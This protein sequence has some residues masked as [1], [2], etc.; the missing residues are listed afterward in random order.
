VVRFGLGQFTLQIPPWDD[1]DP[2]Q[3]YADTLALAKIAE[4]AGFSSFW[5]AE[6]HGAS[7]SYNP[8]LLPFLSAVAA[9]TTTLELGTAV[10]LAPFHNPLRVAEDAAVVDNI[11]GGRLNLGLGLGWAP[12]EYKMFAVEGKGRGKRLEEFVEV[13]RLAW[14]GEPFSFAGSHLSYEDALVRPKPKR[15]I[16]IWLG[17]NMPPAL[18]RAA[19]M[20][21]GHFPPSTGTPAQGVDRGREILAI[22]SR[23]G[24][25]GPF[26]YGM[27]LPTGVGKDADDG[28]A[29]IRDG[30]LHVRGAY[31]LWGQGVTDVTDAR[32]TAAAWED[33]IR[34][35]ALC[36]SPSEILDALAPHVRELDGMGFEDVFISIILAPPGTPLDRA[37]EQVRTFG[38]K[39]IQPLSG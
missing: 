25:S 6:H 24:L 4:D 23:L 20:A 34:A 5:L 31:A 8:A 9:S 39:V 35:T 14:S 33:S 12:H 18:E 16:R 19:R 2:A 15:P 11:S 7:D 26:R 22:R 30:L 21:D 3:L 32:D 36:G 10:M 29:R 13:L 17:G 27:F 37:V 1:R 38:E 28:W